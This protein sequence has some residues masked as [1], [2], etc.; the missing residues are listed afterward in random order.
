[1]KTRKHKAKTRVEAEASETLAPK[2][3]IITMK[4][5]VF[6]FFA[7]SLA[8]QAN[9]RLEPAAVLTLAFTP[10]A[11]APG[12]ASLS[13]EEFKSGLAELPQYAPPTN[14]DFEVRV[15]SA[16]GAAL[17]SFW[18]ADPRYVFFD[19]AGEDDYLAGGTKFNANA[20][21]FVVVPVPAKA[22]YAAVFDS[23]GRKLVAVNLVTGR[24]VED[25]EWRKVEFTAEEKKEG[26]GFGEAVVTT[27]AVVLAI[28]IVLGLLVFRK[29][30]RRV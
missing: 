24:Q 6:A 7:F 30:R 2:N 20:R 16:E 12:G 13:L 15:L 9:A 18:I 17:H 23:S 19:V 29:A 11:T 8:S 25:K 4:I 10:N 22:R 5:V 1:M 21:F 26:F 27:I 3:T 28:L 14:R